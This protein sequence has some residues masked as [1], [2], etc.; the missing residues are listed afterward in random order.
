MIF[1]TSL[2][3]ELIE[4]I[5]KDDRLSLLGKAIRAYDTEGLPV[6]I[7]ETY[8]S[9][10]CKENS[11]KIIENQ[12]G[13]KHEENSIT[14]KLNCFSPLSKSAYGAHSITEKVTKGLCEKFHDSVTAFS[15][16]D[17]QYDDDVKS[18]KISALI[19]FTY[20]A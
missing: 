2:I 17:T 6:P 1:S 9:F 20:K 18:Y 12:D 19:N 16:G 15:V 13:T 8:F 14:I 4:F 5:N 7:R 11:V 3:T 10:S